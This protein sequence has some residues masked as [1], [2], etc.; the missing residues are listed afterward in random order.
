MSLFDRLKNDNRRIL[1]G[2]DMRAVTLT[3]ASGN[4][5]TG[6]ARITAP[7]MD[8][9]MQG[10]AFATKKYSVGFHI[11]AYSSIMATNENFKNWQASFLNSQGETVTGVFNNPLVDKTYGYVVATLT[12]IKAVGN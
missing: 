1:S 4:S 8:I 12:E 11:D 7:G 5:F 6:T 9:N 2:D 10:Q 3:N